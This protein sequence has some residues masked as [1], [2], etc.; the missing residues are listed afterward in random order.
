[1]WLT[2]VGCLTIIYS[3]LLIPTIFCLSIL[4]QVA[5]EGLTKERFGLC[6]SSWEVN[7]N[8]WNYSTQQ[9][10]LCLPGGLG[11]RRISSTSTQA[12]DQSQPYRW[13]MCLCS[14]S[15]MKAMDTKSLISFPGWQHSMHIV[16]PITA[17]LKVISI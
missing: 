4:S 15:S 10:C 1:M 9:E 6:P 12:G 8:P 13:F 5:G 2:Y 17:E 7:S 14:Q 3:P 11:L 16:P